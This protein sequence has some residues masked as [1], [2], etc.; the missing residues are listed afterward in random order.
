MTMM[1]AAIRFPEATPLRRI[2]A[3]AVSKALITFFDIVWPSQ[4]VVQTD[5]G[6]NFMSLVFA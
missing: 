3:S 4:T 5:Q 2:T 6:S 1:C